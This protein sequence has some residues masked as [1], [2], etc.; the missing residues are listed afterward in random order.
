MVEWFGFANHRDFMR[1]VQKGLSRVS[2]HSD[3][4]IERCQ[5]SQ[6]NLSKMESLRLN[7]WSDAQKKLLGDP[8]LQVQAAIRKRLYETQGFKKDRLS[9][10]GQGQIRLCFFLSHTKLSAIDQHF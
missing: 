3:W 5:L 7:S 8:S 6:K 9:K 10:K 4:T 2:F 1:E